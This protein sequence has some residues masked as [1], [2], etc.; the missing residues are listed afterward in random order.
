MIHAACPVCGGVGV[1][2]GFMGKL[3]WFRCRYCGWEFSITLS[4]AS[5]PEPELEEIEE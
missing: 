4:E 5:D 1:M 3:I 2:L